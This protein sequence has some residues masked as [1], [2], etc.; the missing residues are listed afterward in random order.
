[1]AGILAA[2]AVVPAGAAQASLIGDSIAG[3]FQAPNAIPGDNLWDDVGGATTATP[4]TAVV[5]AGVE[6]S[7]TL[8]FTLTADLGPASL[9]LAMDTGSGGFI[10]DDLI[11]D[12]TGLDLPGSIGNVLL[13]SSDLSGV[14]FS[15]DDHSIHVEIPNQTVLGGTVTVNFDIVAAAIPEPGTL[16]LL[17]SAL[18]GLALVRRRR[19]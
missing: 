19:R 7:V 5:G 4:I 14:T 15:F 2:A 1:M 10:G 9:S 17:G 8:G 3:V 11:Y 12:F 6:F 18:A 16:A 13:S